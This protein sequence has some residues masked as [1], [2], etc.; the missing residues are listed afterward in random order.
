MP[1]KSSIWHEI[2]GEEVIGKVGGAAP[3]RVRSAKTEAAGRFAA[4]F[5][6]I[7]SEWRVWVCGVRRYVLNDVPVLG[8]FAV[9]DPV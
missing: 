9:L 2:E 5:A 6:E 4:N 3:L 1:R 8:D 7:L